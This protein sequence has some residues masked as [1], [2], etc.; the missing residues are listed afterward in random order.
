MI[1]HGWFVFACGLLLPSG[2]AE[3]QLAGG[4]YCSSDVFND[5]PPVEGASVIVRMHPLLSRAR[6]ADAVRNEQWSAALQGLRS[7]AMQAFVAAG[8][9]PARQL[10]FLAQLDSVLDYLPRIPRDTTNDLRAR[11]IGDSVRPIRFAPIPG[12][13]SYQLFRRG[14]RIDI[15]GLP[16]DE[17][18]ALCWSALSV[19]LVLFRLTK[20]LELASLARLARLNTAWTNYRT[21]GY[22]RQPLELFLT[23]GSVHDSLPRTGQWLIGHLSLGMQVSGSS[24]DS[25]TAVEAGVIEFG[26]LWYRSNYT[27]YGG[28]SA[29]VALPARNVIGY[30]GMIHFAR[31]LRGG[32]VFHHA[33]GRTTRSIILSTDLYGMLEHSKQWVDQGSS[34]ARGIVVLP[35]RS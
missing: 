20:P 32:L 18:K 1:R 6:Y 33:D 25:I 15:A 14:E 13:T 16:G 17:A 10:T 5:A 30:G 9:A 31:S 4:Q 29:L 24:A 2:I 22:T 27:Q 35:P 7:D 34:I 3:G 19:D 11:F 21:Y 8:V 23:P 12:T 26:H 28:L